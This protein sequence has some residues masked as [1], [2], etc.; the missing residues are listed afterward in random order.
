MSNSIIAE[1]KTS[2]EA[3]N[4][5]LKQLNVSK[6]KVDIK[7]LENKVKKSFFSILAPRVVQVEI[8]LKEQIQ[9]KKVKE[10][11]STPKKQHIKSIDTSKEELEQVKEIIENL[12]KSLT[13]SYNCNINIRIKDITIYVNIDG[14]D[15][16][17]LIGYRGENLTAIETLLITVA[18]KSCDS[19]V[20]VNLDICNYK[21]KRAKVLES[22]AFNVGKNVE[23]N[24][25]S[26]TLD[27]MSTYERKIVHD[28]LQNNTKIESHSIGLDPNR[29][30]VVSLKK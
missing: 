17:K 3:I 28:V 20:K 14:E 12:V 16:P 27:P 7:I 19:R 18:F 23:K 11:E 9:I 21:S 15:A 2:T 13:K 24:G 4:N 6:D 10:V 26:I 29:R 1:G 8:T 25:K 5:G 30:I 22:L